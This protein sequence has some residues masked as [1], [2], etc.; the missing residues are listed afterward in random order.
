[1]ASRA[2]LILFTKQDPVYKKKMKTMQMSV[3]EIFPYKQVVHYKYSLN[4]MKI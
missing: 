4:I 3:D 2:S 1:M